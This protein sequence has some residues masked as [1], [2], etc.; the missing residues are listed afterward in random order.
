MFTI[1]GSGFGL[2]GYLPALIDGVKGKVCLPRKY[3]KVVRARDD[4]SRLER[5]ILWVEDEVD[6]VLHSNK[7]VVSVN[8]SQQFDVIRRCVSTGFRGDF[9]LEKPLAKSPQ[10]AV[11]LLDFLDDSGLGYSIGYSFL[12]IDELKASLSNNYDAK[13]LILNWEFMAYHFAKN[14][15]NWKRF[16]TEGGGVLRF[17]GIHVIALL[18]ESGYSGVAS[19]I[20]TGERKEEP[21][22]WEAVF[23][24]PNA[25]DC[26]VIVDSRSKKSSFSVIGKGRIKPLVVTDPFELNNNQAETSDRRFTSLVNFISDVDRPVRQKMLYR[27]INRMWCLVERHS[28]Y[29]NS[30]EGNL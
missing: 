9:F 18:V 26:S 17:Y 15:S 1:F 3:I 2:Y 24:H 23:T 19:S 14:L 28:V 4:L 8:P 16:N 10:E 13:Q 30:E 12:Y 11:K 20:L 22:R 7:V 25:V 5:E 6:A 21:S 29:K 27:E